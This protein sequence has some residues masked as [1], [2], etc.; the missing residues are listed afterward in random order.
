MSEAISR[1]ALLAGSA[2]LIVSARTLGAYAPSNRVT[3]GVIGVGRQTV[4]VKLKKF[5]EM[6]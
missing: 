4:E 6:W 3:V 5:L 2:P 1:R